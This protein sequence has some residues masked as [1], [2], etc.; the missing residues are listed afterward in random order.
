MAKVKVYNLAGEAVKDAELLPEL[1]EVEVNPILVQQAVVVQQAN[2][3]VAIAHT[4]D[5]SEVRGGGKKPWRQKGTGRAR[6]GS[7]RSPIWIGGGITF[8]PRAE[9]NFSKNIN[10]KMRQKA[11]KMVLSD[12]VK[13]GKLVLVDSI[14]LPEVKTKQVSTAL[15]KLPANEAKRTMVVLHPGSDK[16]ALS[17]RNLKNVD[18]IAAN[19]LNVKDLLKSQRLVVPMQSLQI[20]HEL[21]ASKK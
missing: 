6:H 5:R 11:L 1:F 4:K 3:R 17:A 16:F 12:K 21:Y 10:K 20:I 18:L 19:S 14:D 15:T 13:E 7:S 8:G 9:R 2:E